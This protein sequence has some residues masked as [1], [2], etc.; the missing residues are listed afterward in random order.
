MVKPHQLIKFLVNLPEN[1]GIPSKAIST[2]KPKVTKIR[3]K[4]LKSPYEPDLFV[5]NFFLCCSVQPENL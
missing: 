1:S 3:S 2:E 5:L 4:A